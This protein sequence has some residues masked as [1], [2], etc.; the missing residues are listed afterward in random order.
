MNLQNE[1][2]SSETKLLVVINEDQVLFCKPGVRGL[3]ILQSFVS[4]TKANTRIYSLCQYQWNS[5]NPK[6]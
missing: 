6:Q 5:E 3:T 2:D 1:S 4:N